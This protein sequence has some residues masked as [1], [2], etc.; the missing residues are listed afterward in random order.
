MLLEEDID[1]Y[2]ESISLANAVPGVG[3]QPTP[4]TAGTAIFK[5]HLET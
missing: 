4:G 1:L 5:E 2:S 3:F